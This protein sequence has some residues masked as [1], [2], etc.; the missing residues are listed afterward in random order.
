MPPPFIVFALCQ[1]GPA[2]STHWLV[3]RATT[4]FLSA[5]AQGERYKR[6]AKACFS[7]PSFTMPGESWVIEVF[8]GKNEAHTCH[9]I[10][11]YTT[12]AKDED[13]AMIAGQLLVQNAIA[14]Q[15]PGFE[16]LTLSEVF[17]MPYRCA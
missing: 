13:E 10:R 4:P 16:G 1:D 9:F 12:T 7:F 5:H 15:K 2:E 6:G 14:R 11:K 3:K 17:I 8:F